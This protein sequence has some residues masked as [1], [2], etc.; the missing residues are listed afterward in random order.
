MATATRDLAPAILG[1]S[2][3]LS[4]AQ[5]EAALDPR[6]F[7]EKRDIPG[8]PGALKSASEEAEAAYREVQVWLDAKRGLLA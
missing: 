5:L 4:D 2:L 1:R 3:N 8:G 6:L 7:V